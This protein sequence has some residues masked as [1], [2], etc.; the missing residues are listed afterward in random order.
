MYSNGE[1]ERYEFCLGKDVLTDSE[2][3]VEPSDCLYVQL[4]A[5]D[6][7]GCSELKLRSPDALVGDID[8]HVITGTELVFMQVYLCVHLFIRFRT[9]ICMGDLNLAN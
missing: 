4:T 3:C 9:F 7:T 5:S 2:D 6:I 1:L 8:Y